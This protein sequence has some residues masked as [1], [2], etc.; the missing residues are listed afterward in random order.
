MHKFYEELLDRFHEL[1][2]EVERALEE[3]PSEA[4]DWQP[5]KDM[6]SLSVLVTHLAGAERYWIGDVARGDPSDRD[7]DAE[8][9][10]KGLDAA[11]LQRRIRELEAYE[12]T[13]FESMS[14]AELEQ[15]RRSPRDGWEYTV[16]WALAHA[17][18]HT[19]VHIGHIQMLIQLWKQR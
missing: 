14:L 16:A 8:F 12:K 11:G 15:Y 2:M 7:R 4:L 6:N 19:A 5:G 3:I 9:Q 18:E 13:S 10:V 17:L 1:H